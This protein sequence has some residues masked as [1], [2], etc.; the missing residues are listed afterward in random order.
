MK[1]A[2]QDANVLIDLELA[3]LFDP[4]FQVG[5]ETHTTSLIRLE[6]EAG[7]HD[8][9]LAY[10]TGG[11]IHEHGLSF[12]ELS[13]VARLER[14]VGSKARFNDCSVLFL[15]RKLDAMLLSSDKALRQAAQT[16]HVEVHGTLWIMDQL[17]ERKLISSVTAAAKL[18]FLL[19][20]E[21]FF[22]RTE[23]E[24]RLKKWRSLA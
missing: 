18:Q 7:H 20:R 13:E 22:P 23:C 2:V 24:A 21:R 3:G 12:A 14:A 5:I 11:Q 4:W 10:F 9:T 8:Q 17:I 1:I 16:R 19:S 15:A 6:L